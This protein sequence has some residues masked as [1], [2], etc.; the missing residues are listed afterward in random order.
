MFEKFDSALHEKCTPAD[1]LPKRREEILCRIELLHRM[2]I[3][4]FAGYTDVE[5]N[6]FLLREAVE[7]YFCDIDRLKFFRGILQEDKHKQAAFFIV[8]IAKIRPIQFRTGIT[9][10]RKSELYANEFFAICAGL[11][12]LDCSITK[13]HEQEPKYLTN[14]V[15]LLH[16]H[17]C[18]GEQLA[19]EMF[20][21]DRLLTLV[22][23]LNELIFGHL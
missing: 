19:S 3:D 15:Y 23:P 1:I 8:W 7:S 5:L 4:L 21:L 13:L 10:T 18:S 2:F 12:F 6:L 17:S 9:I 16:F 22:D 11:T 20:L 14:L